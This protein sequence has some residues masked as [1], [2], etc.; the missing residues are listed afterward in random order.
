L[1]ENWREENATHTRL[2]RKNGMPASEGK[3]TELLGAQ[4]LRQLLNTS[5]ARMY[6]RAHLSNRYYHYRR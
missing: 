1:E 6:L 5:G 3:L 4:A 2:F